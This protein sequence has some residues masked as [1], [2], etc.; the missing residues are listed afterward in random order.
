[1]QTHNLIEDSF[2]KRKNLTVSHFD[3]M[4]DDEMIVENKLKSI[5]AAI[6]L[7]ITPNLKADPTQQNLDGDKSSEETED[8]VMSMINKSVA[9]VN[10]ILSNK[11]PNQE[12][13]SILKSKINSDIGNVFNDSFNLR[14]SNIDA[15]Q[16][17]P[18]IMSAYGLTDK[19]P[20]YSKVKSILD[21]LKSEFTKNGVQS[22]ELM[23]NSIK[24]L[25]LLFDQKIISKI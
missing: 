21:K 17:F 13:I 19:D 18:M 3:E 15:S 6:L 11:T 23:G 9:V 24:M 22:K 4:I 20:E 12:Q 8:K 1:M 25:E 16:Y 10:K 7:G 2:F 14:V 5:L